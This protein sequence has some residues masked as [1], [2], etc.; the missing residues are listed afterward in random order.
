MVPV[1]AAHTDWDRP[2]FLLEGIQPALGTGLLQLRCPPAG[3]SPA[4]GGQM[5]TADVAELPRRAVGIVGTGVQLGHMPSCFPLEVF[6]S[7]CSDR[8]FG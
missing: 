7:P 5:D 2:A 3:Q 4:V 1:T 8:Q 6:V